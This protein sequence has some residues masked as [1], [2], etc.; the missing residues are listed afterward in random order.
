MTRTRPR[1]S[2]RPLPVRF[3]LGLY[4]ASASLQLAVVLIAVCGGVLA[5]ATFVESKFDTPVVQFGI[6]HT[7][8][9]AVLNLLLALNVLCAAL[10]RLPWKKRQIGFLITHAGILVILAGSAVTRW[11]GIDG[12]VPIVEADTVHRGYL[13][14]QHFRLAIQG[15]GETETAAVRFRGGPFNW[16]EYQDRFWFPWRLAR[17]DRGTLYEQDGIKLEVLDYY[18]DSTYAPAPSLRLHVHNPAMRRAHAAD[19]MVEMPTATTIDLGILPDPDPALPNPKYGRGDAASVLRAGWISFRMTGSRKETEAFTDGGPEGPLGQLGQVVLQAGGKK[20][21]LPLDDYLDPEART[22]HTLRRF[23]LGTTGLAVGVFDFDPKELRVA[24]QVFRRNQFAGWLLLYANDPEDNQQDYASGVFGTYWFEATMATARMVPRQRFERARQRRVEI[25]QGHDRKLYYRTWDAPALVGSGELPT[26]GSTLSL[27]AEEGNPLEIAVERYLPSDEP[28]R[29]V[30]LPFR[31]RT[32]KRPQARVR[33][34]VDG[35]A[36]EFWL[37]GRLTYPFDY[38]VETDQ[39]RTVR[40]KKRSVE[41]GMLPDDVELGFSIHLREFIEELYPGMHAVKGYS[42]VVDVFERPTDEDG[43]E[44]DSGKALHEETLIT[45]NAPIDVADP[46]TKR[47]YRLS[48][49]SRMGPWR[50]EKSSQIQRLVGGKTKRNRV[51]ASVLG[52]NYDPGRGL[53]Y[54]GSLMIVFGIIVVLYVR[55]YLTRKSVKRNGL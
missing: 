6:Y 50:P 2:G 42:S 30:P 38:P 49:S 13:D 4:R 48:Q 47:T 14:S 36:E 29:L 52:L 31:K 24:L 17:R 28:G 45:M 25:L 8:W 26:D 51:Y 41:I 54:A 1:P 3:L 37:A 55:M 22:G 19:E 23:P 15:D 40:G 18:S 39:A 5:W 33:L 43:E 27:F 44:D 11:K 35:T 12:S 9:F 53:K 10:I 16:S 7:W 20:Y 21:H 46:H 34:T 32:I